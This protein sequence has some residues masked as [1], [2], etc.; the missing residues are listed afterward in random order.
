RGGDRRGSAGGGEIG[1]VVRACGTSTRYA[2]FSSLGRQLM[3]AAPYAPDVRVQLFMGGFTP[4]EQQA[5]LS[6]HVR[7]AC[8]GFDPYRDVLDTMID[9]PSDDALERLIYHHAKLY[10]AGQTLVKMDRATM[11][12]GLEGRASYLD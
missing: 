5:L 1:R 10:L 6:E 3:R 8:A 9:A 7:A 4:S 12:F 11:A 2:S